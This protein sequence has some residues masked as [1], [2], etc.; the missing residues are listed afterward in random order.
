ML[1]LITILSQKE[2]LHVECKLAQNELPNSLWETYSAF[3]NTSGGVI[4]LGIKESGGAFTPNGVDNPDQMITDLWNTLNNQ[5]KIS[6]NILFDHHIYVQTLNGK[7][8]IVIEV[9]RANRQDRPVYV[10]DQLFRGCYRRNGE[11]D[12]RC[13]RE[14]VKAML[15]DQAETGPD[16]A[17]LEHLTLDVLNPDSIR[18]YRIMFENTKP[19]H[20]WTRL[21]NDEFLVK[22]GAARRLPGHQTLHPT[23][24]GLIFFGEF[25]EITNELPN[26]FLDYREHLS[27]ETR[28][29]DRV[30][31]GDGDWS[32]NVFDFYFKIIDRILS[33]VKT[34]FALKNGITRIDETP[35]HTALR[36]ALANCLIHA[37]YFG[38]RGI[39]IDKSYNKIT[40]S[41]PGTFR[42]SI[43]E[44]IGGG[45]S[46]A[47]NSKIFNMFT[48]I[49]VGERS[50]TGLCD[51]FSVW[52]SHGFKTPEIAE[53]ITPERVTLI[54]EMEP[55]AYNDE[56]PRLREDFSTHH[57]GNVLHDGRNLPLNEG[58][59][60]QYEGNLSPSEG[61]AFLNEGNLH[62]EVKQALYPIRG[63]CSE[64]QAAIIKLL[65]SDPKLS[66]TAIAQ[67]LNVSRATI[68]RDLHALKA[69]HRIWR[70]G[71]TRGIWVVL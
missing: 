35:I 48:L 13:T 19:H 21:N 34:P 59:Q 12:Y 47:R 38:R 52:R 25:I 27:N 53:S 56:Y 30:C 23:L 2:N 10:G 17:I 11:G 61:I 15:R 71:G 65:L 55:E 46:D 29:T 24:A 5:Q 64:R 36:E 32:G 54:L 57:E 1:D 20:T 45:I 58:N 4:L 41:N 68:E 16:N 6:A 63:H 8:I 9:P 31:S 18:R 62:Q 43:D 60:F 66:A 70:D 37:D 28:W 49:N 3:A 22:I 40:L 50:G 42:I 51:L 33:D 39:V 7:N 67:I 69:A 26:Y 14:E 44:A